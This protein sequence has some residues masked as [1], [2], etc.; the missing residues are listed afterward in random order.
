MN[1]NKIVRQEPVEEIII[2]L[3][4]REEMLNELRQVSL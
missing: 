2:P 1:N 3:E 4:K